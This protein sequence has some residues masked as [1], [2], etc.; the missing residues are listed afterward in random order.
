MNR[1]ATDRSS[2]I[3]YLFAGLTYWALASIFHLKVS[4]FLISPLLSGSFR[5]ADYIWIVCLIL[6]ALLLAWVIGQFLRRRVGIPFVI[7]SLLWVIAVIGAN[8]FLVSTT[9]EYVHYP[10]YAL[11]ALFLYLYLRTEKRPLP[12]SRVLFWA[13]LLGVIDEAV[14]YF[15]I[16]PSYGEYLDFNDFILNQ[17]GA[18]AG[19]ILAVSFGKGTSPFTARPSL[20]IPEAVAFTAIALAISAA[21]YSGNLKITP[22][23]EIPPGG[24]MRMQDGTTVFLERRPGAMGSWQKAQH[25]GSYYVLTSFEGTALMFGIIAAA[26][27][28]ESLSFPRMRS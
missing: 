24:L 28:L 15:Y 22:P 3:L 20:G 11:T 12:V 19:I 2:R 8:R 17:L 25:E 13:T 21:V 14:Q 27:F 16:C 23:R 6:G 18:C 9:N 1:V 26:A 4:L 7:I 10:Q 5:L